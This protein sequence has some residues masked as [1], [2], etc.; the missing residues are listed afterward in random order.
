MYDYSYH[1]VLT[2]YLPLLE[3]TWRIARSHFF[4]YVNKTIIRFLL[5]VFAKCYIHD[6]VCK[7][8]T[9]NTYSKQ[10]YHK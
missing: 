3:I 4:S 9:R 5:N 1:N 6:N 10:K 7:N 8:Y 2:Y